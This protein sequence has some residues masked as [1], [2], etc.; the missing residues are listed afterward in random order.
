MDFSKS[1]TIKVKIWNSAH[2]VFKKTN[3]N[4]FVFYCLV[5]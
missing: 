3:T 2:F 1:A 5:G 4:A